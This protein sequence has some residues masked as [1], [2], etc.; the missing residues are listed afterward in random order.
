M[1][2]FILEN[3]LFGAETPIKPIGFEV[4]TP[5]TSINTTDTGGNFVETVVT[6]A[7][8]SDV[9]IYDTDLDLPIINDG[10]EAYFVMVTLFLSNEMLG[11]FQRTV[12]IVSLNSMNGF[13][14]ET[15]RAKFIEDFM[16]NLNQ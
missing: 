10:D 5:E 2:K 9:I 11:K 8:Y 15:Q 6:P 1:E 16:A 14:V 7:T 3:V 12:M 13:E 4:L